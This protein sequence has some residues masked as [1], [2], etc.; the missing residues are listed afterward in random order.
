M[1]ARASKSLYRST[2]YLCNGLNLLHRLPVRDPDNIVLTEPLAKLASGGFCH[3]ERM[4]EILLINTY[5]ISPFSR[6]DSFWE[7]FKKLNSRD[8][9]HHLLKTGRCIIYGFWFSGY[10]TLCVIGGLIRPWPTAILNIEKILTTKS[11]KAFLYPVVSSR[12]SCASW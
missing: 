3:L 10:P 5:K 8:H 9:L 6:N 2:N 7:L 1:P 4:W 12:S 11:T